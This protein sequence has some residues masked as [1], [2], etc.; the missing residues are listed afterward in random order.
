MSLE[1]GATKE[2]L[3][4]K[5]YV[6]PPAVESLLSSPG[7]VEKVWP[8]GIMHNELFQ[9]QIEER[10]TISGRIDEVISRL[11]RPDISLQ[12]AI[13]DGLITEGQA[14]NL[15]ASLSDL[16]ENV[17]YKRVLLY[18]PF[19][20]LP[21]ADWKTDSEVLTR[22]I[23]RFKLAYMA[24]WSTQLRTHDVR[25]N[26]VDGDVLEVESRIGDLPRVVKAAHLIPR[27]V[28][29]HLIKVESI[30]KLIETSDDKV[31]KQSIKDSLI[32]SADLGL[33]T[34][35]E[36]TRMHVSKDRVVRDAANIIA[37]LADQ[38]GIKAV[39][40]ESA[41]FS[42]GALLHELN[43]VDAEYSGV[44]QK[45]AL[46]LRQEKKRK[47]IEAAANKIGAAIARDTFPNE[48]IEELTAGAAASE[49]QQVI[50]L[51]IRNAIE[52]TA[53]LNIRR[54][55]DLYARFENTLLS[56][57]NNNKL[58]VH[59]TL[60]TT[61]YR[62]HD[63]GIAD[64]K[65]LSLLQ[66][67]VPALTGPSSK[68]LLSMQEDMNTVQEIGATLESDLELSRYI[69]PV[70][71]IFGSKLKGYGATSADIDVAVFVKPN[72]SFRE[73]KKIG[74]AL[75]NKFAHE[76]LHGEIVEFWLEETPT[77]L[78]VRDFDKTDVSL[79]ESYWTHIL[80]GAAWVGDKQAI[81]ELQEKLLV[82]YFYDTGKMIQGRLAR[83]LYLEELERD[84][85]QYR[86]MH[87]GYARF[88]VPRGG[89][90]S[91]HANHVDGESMFWDS[92]FRQLALRLFAR[93]VFLP[94][95]TVVS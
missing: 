66:L 86:L 62:L 82:S 74:Q 19:E 73:R 50:I 13:S 12:Q 28:Q 47:A 35:T 49:N 60:T 43:K 52:S 34:D 95:L 53:N 68:N 38:G 30:L 78:S 4:K 22:S 54:A 48:Q 1:K 32:V 41:P 51:G 24:A 85:L 31:L 2:E 27:L 6:A 46:W 90:H 72:V 10:R 40:T 20:F 16:L 64:E 80:F 15:Y 89:I 93:R 18:I 67:P 33:I 94:K 58:E 29:N 57:W 23:E 42:P 83:G 77:G 36:L 26:F 56:L 44:T 37:S 84:T 65:Q 7:R 55:K 81:R 91:P 76:K 69:Y 79:G 88:F 59:E 92:G 87:K 70:T 11:P 21:N 5:S 17:D 14:A 63:L 71:L 75:K 8:E 39:E 3:I 25:A 45:R 61:F 9:A